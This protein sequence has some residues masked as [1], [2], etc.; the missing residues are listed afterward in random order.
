MSLLYSVC[1]SSA[2]I[3]L[4]VSEIIRTFAEHFRIDESR[5]EENQRDRFE[6]SVEE[7]IYCHH[8]S[9]VVVCR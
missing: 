1:H 4:L 6:D 2:V 7:S 8:D 5:H 9:Q 3:F